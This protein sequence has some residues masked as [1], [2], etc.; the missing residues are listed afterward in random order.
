[1][2]RT[3]DETGKTLT[4][5]VRY[6]INKFPHDAHSES[7]ITV[8]VIQ[9]F[10]YEHL[11]DGHPTVETCIY[12]PNLADVTKIMKGMHHELPKLYKPWE[13]DI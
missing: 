7:M 3:I 11:K 6:C 2:G 8:H 12:L 4:G 10:F 13:T 9:V 1:M 5:K